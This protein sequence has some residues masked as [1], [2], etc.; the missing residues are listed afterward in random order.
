MKIKVA[1]LEQDLTYLNRIT[2]AFHT[3][4]SDKMEI[5]GFT[6]YEKALEELKKTKIDVFL[7]DEM[8][9]VEKSSIPKAC[10]FAYLVDSTGIETVR[11]TIAISKFQK[12][13]LIYKQILSIYS[14]KTENISGGQMDN[15]NCKVITF[16]SA[17]GGTGASSMAAACAKRY[18]GSGRKVLYLNLEKFGTTDQFFT[19]E[20][21][22][23]MSDIIFALK[24]KKA[25]LS[26]KI[27]SSVRQD[28]SGVRFFSQPGIALDLMELN[29][30]DIRQLVME[31][32]NIGT[33]EYIILDM[34]FE[35]RMEMAML[36]GM[37]NEIVFVG[38]GTEI[39]NKKTL[40][41]IKAIGA[42]EKNLNMPILN[43]CVLMYNRFHS[44]TGKIL[45]NVPLRTLG[46]APTYM[47]ATAEQVVGQLAKMQMFDEII[48]Q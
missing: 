36:Y 7:A 30:D 20:G 27:E 11:D 6:V 47:Q 19:G 28:M 31:I 23:S 21:Q 35:V 9:D 4:Y 26:M 22:F 40:Q 1:I 38:D 45:E 14:E 12:A 42:L 3:R 29:T 8:F 32:R 24:G 25:N 34:D 46:G 43:H 44:K 33:Y 5:Y 15:G 17:A 13:D 16:I 48:R 37:M 10:G 2:A 41:G 39:S 18:A